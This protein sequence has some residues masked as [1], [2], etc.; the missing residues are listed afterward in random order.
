MRRVSLAL[1]G[2]RK[3]PCHDISMNDSLPIS[4]PPKVAATSLL[5]EGTN[6]QSIQFAVVP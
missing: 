5:E 6:K 3:L 2:G 1:V 4:K